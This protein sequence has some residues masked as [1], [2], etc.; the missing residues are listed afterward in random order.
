MNDTN[1]CPTCGSGLP[2]EV[3]EA[4][5]EAAKKFTAWN[6][7]YPSSRIYNETSIRQIAKELDA[8]NDETI[9]AL[10]NIEKV[11]SADS[12]PLR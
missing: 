5:I 8:I 2:A 3:V 9:E 10:A 1:K 12:P 4:L 6:K 7:K 11:N